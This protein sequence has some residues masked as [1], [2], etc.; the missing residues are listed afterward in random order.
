MK[1]VLILSIA[2]ILPIAL[3][4]LTKLNQ[5][6]IESLFGSSD[7]VYATVLTFFSVVITALI[8]TAMAEYKMFD[9]EK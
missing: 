6:L 3:I 7:V 2:A 1:K 8:Y 9:K 4:L 5:F